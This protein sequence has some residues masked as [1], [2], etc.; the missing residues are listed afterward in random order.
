M[1]NLEAVKLL[2]QDANAE[3]ATKAGLVRVR[4]AGAALGLSAAEQ[5]ELERLMEYRGFDGELYAYLTTTKP[6]RR[7]SASGDWYA[8]GRK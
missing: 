4:K 7:A 8:G 1:T 5:I 2:L 3:K 6:R